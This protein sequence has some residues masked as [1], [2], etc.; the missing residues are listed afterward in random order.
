MCLP[1]VFS[2]IAV[3][4]VATREGDGPEAKRGGIW[5]ALRSNRAVAAWAMGEL[6]AWS[7]WGGTLTFAGA[8]IVESYEPSP[9]L[10]GLLL[11]G[12][13]AAYFPGN[14]FARRRASESPQTVL[15]VHGVALAAVVSVFGCLRPSLWFSVAMFA[16]IVAVAGGRTLAGSATGL[17]AAPSHEVAAMSI[18]AAAAQ[19]GIVAG[20]GLGAAALAVGGYGLLGMVLSLLFAAGTLPH[21]AAALPSQLTKPRR[22]LPA[23]KGARA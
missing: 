15:V 13:A 22:P 9:P 23:V 1:V 2:A 19:L 4:V 18:R 20:A 8:L 16:L 21:L 17:A 7:A 12:A 3:A 5:S 14:L 11:A 6:L 10:V